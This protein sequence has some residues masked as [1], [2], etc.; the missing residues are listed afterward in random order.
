ME[1]I[2]RVIE[3]KWADTFSIFP[4]GDIHLGSIDSCELEVSDQMQK[5]VKVPRSLVIG[6]GDYADC[7][8]KNDPRFTVS[9]LA[10]WVTKDDVVESQRK[11]VVDLFKPLGNRVLAMLAGNHE[12][13]I[14]LRHQDDIIRHICDDL[15]VPYGGYSCYIVLTFKRVNSNESHQ[16]VI[17]AWHGSGAAQ[18]EGARLNR[19]LRLVNEVEARIYLMGHL[20]C[21]AQYT[22]DRLFYRNGRVRSIK[23]AAATTGSWLKAY[24]QPNEGQMLNPSYAEKKGYK[25]SRIGCPVIHIKPETDEVTVEA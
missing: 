18:T 14:H 7:I 3:Y 24:N 4:I 9:G 16:Y 23:L 1:V 2:E 19:L 20:H 21:M 5:I 6:M 17:H 13:E 10:D 15:E 8:T 22:P 25:P 11:H 12:E